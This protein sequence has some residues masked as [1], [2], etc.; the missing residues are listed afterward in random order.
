M[1][2]LNSIFIIPARK[3]SKG[4]PNKNVRSLFGR[5]LISYSIEYAISVST[6]KDIIC[7]TSDDER[8]EKITNKYN[9]VQFIKRP[10]VLAKDKSSMESVINHVVKLY[11]KNRI[12]FESIVLLQPTSPIRKASDFSKIKKK[13]KNTV[14]MV[15][16]VKKAKENPYY[17]LYEEDKNGYLYKSKVSKTIR[18]QDAPIV[19]CL[20]GSFFMIRTN[21]LKKKSILDFSKILKV[22]MPPERSIDID[23]ESDWN[24]LSF[25]INSKKIKLK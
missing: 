23:N 8:I 11:E 3:G 12:S 2:K 17:L 10:K 18:R 7:V 20:N 1:K 9:Q 19:Y 4:M 25:L 16:S 15:V 21:S 22:E 5:P 13:F 6:P 24:Y 14:D